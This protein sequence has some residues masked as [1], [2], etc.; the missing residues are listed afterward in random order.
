M[1]I[2][3]RFLYGSGTKTAGET[4]GEETHVL[5]INEMPSHNHNGI[6]TKWQ[7]WVSTG[8]TCGPESGSNFVVDYNGGFTTNNTG[9]NWAHNN[10]PPY[11]VV[12]IWKR[13]A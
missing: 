9:G 6:T 3:D 8:P 13:V 1:A 11:E 10:M 12:Y 2:H 5:T 4:G 7:S